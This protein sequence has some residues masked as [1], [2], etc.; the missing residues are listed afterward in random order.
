MANRIVSIDMDSSAI[1]V[2]ELRDN[3]VRQWV[4]APVE[5]GLMLNGTLTDPS[6]VGSRVREVLDGSGITGGGINGKR[7]ISSLSGLFSVYRLIDMEEPAERTGETLL[8]TVRNAVPEQGLTLRYQHISPD[9]PGSL[10]HKILVL[11][12]PPARVDAQV[13]MI[14]SAKL[15]PTAIE[16]KGIA[17]A[18]AVDTSPGIIVNVEQTSLD[19]VVVSESLP[20]I[21]RTLAMPPDLQPKDRASLVTRALEQTIA[22]Y[23]DRNSHEPLPADT[24]LFIVGPEAGEQS[25]WEAVQAEIGYPLTEFIPG[26]E[27]P[28]QFPASHFAVNLGLAQRDQERT[29]R[30][31]GNDGVVPLRVNLAPA[32]T[33]VWR[34][35]PVATLALAIVLL[36]LA[37]GF[38]MNSDLED[39]RLETEQIRT[40]LDL[41]ERQLGQRR[42]QLVDQQ[43]MVNRMQKA[44]DWFD[45]TTGSQGD[46]TGIVTRLTALELPGITLNSVTSQSD[47][48]TISAQAAGPEAALAFVEALREMGDLG[49]INY[50]S[51][52]SGPQ[53]ISIS[54]PRVR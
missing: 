43:A 29:A 27:H 49:E 16:T 42:T 30:N 3:R 51:I 53:A 50:S 28:P 31:S 40:R 12:S 24:P 41:V 34:L 32:R 19:I 15:T 46:L 7:V 4:S 48:I 17:L 2:L 14:D 5:P 6:A 13:E 36:G 22:Y 35:P 45:S 18:R 37:I 21:M 8:Q 54:T 44:I 10:D 25:V 39:A 52:R 11:G 26:V 38:F 23:H 1:R 20:E 47:S 33:S 9:D